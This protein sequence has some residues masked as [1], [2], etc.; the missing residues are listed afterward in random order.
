MTRHRDELVDVFLADLG[1]G[2]PP[3]GLAAAVGERLRH[4]GSRRP[5][6]VSPWLAAAAVLAL[7]ALASFAWIVAGPGPSPTPQPSAPIPPASAPAMSPSPSA[8][9]SP[10]VLGDWTVTVNPGEPD[11]PVAVAVLDRSGAMTGAGEATQAPPNDGPS[12]PHAL[13]IGQ[14]SDDRSLTVGWTGSV[15]DVHAQ[16]ELA[17]DGRTVALRF[18]P[19][20]SCD[21]LGVGFSIELRFGTPVD[22]AAFHG[23]WSEDLVTISDVEPNVVAF[24]DPDHGWVGGT[25]PTAGD[26]VV[27]ETTDGG[28]S[29]RVEGLGTGRLTDVAVT[30]RGIAWAGLACDE[31]GPTCRP[32]LYRRDDSGL[33]SRVSVDWPVTLSFAGN[34][35]A[36]LFVT[37]A[38]L[39]SQDGLPGPGIR[40]TEDGGDTWRAIPSP[41]GAFD[42]V[43]AVRVTAAQVLALCAGEGGAGEAFKWLYR[44]DPA[45]DPWQLLASTDDGSMPIS[46]TGIRIDVA[47]DQTGWLWGSRTPLLATTDGGATWRP[48]DVADGDVRIVRDADAS[49]GGGGTI[50]VWDP[51]RDGTLL[52]QTD[53]GKAWTQRYLF[54]SP[55]RCCG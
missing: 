4:E 45:G 2:S 19:R 18:P 40:V 16:L 14:G 32:G 43:D 54:P 3:P 37:A 12:D 34:A 41:C 49:G 31:P 42:V 50:L 15:C 39:A 30:G 55:V 48:L 26:A 20:P 22:P 6:R 51:D 8:T 25:T 27:L 36:G 47:E 33:W 13:A 23:T 1:A 7:L 53:D 38:S 17:S 35:G 11:V 5:S 24:A 52:L 21:T 10:Q 44:S 29:W 46:G 9:G 28:A